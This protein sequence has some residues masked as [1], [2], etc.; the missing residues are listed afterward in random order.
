M[1][2]RLEA[3]DDDA[4]ADLLARAELA[5]EEEKRLLKEA[6]R[7]AFTEVLTALTRGKGKP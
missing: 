5:R 7:D 1:D 4:Y 2:W 3:V 6:V